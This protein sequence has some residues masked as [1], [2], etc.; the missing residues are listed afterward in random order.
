MRTV[1]ILPVKSFAR[2]KQRLGTAVDAPDRAE[3]AGAM[4]EDVLEA[5]G[6]VDGLDDVV[7]VTAE[8]RAAQAARAAGAHVVADP[9]EAGQSAAVELG[10]ASAPARRAPRLLLVPGDCPGLDPAEVAALLARPAA[11]PAV[12]IVPD[13]H[14]SGTNALLV[15]PPDALVPS[16]GHGSFA[17]HA[18]RAAAAG[19]HVSVVQAA[20]LALDVDTPGDLEALRAAL[21]ARPGGAPRT[22]A[23]L[24]RLVPLA[25]GA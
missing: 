16:F 3:L 14:G 22:R 5:L 4:V 8:E 7:V 6:A 9:D 1:A 10:M 18:A 19:A 15:A 21:A 11:A 20:S 25:A 17:R 13:R 2:A 24:D 23:V 12:V